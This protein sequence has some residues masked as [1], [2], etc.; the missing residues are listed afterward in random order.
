MHIYRIRRHGAG[1][2]SEVIDDERFCLGC[3]S[4][5]YTDAAA[6]PHPSFLKSRI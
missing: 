2:N 5:P 1:R 4:V 3:R 6:R